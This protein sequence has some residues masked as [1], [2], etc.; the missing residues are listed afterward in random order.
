M[1]GITRLGVENE[2]GRTKSNQKV[3][4]KKNEMGRRTISHT[5]ISTRG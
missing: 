2:V 3:F 1:I 4:E 5:F